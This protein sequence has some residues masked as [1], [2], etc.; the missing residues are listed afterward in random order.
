MLCCFALTS[1][2]QQNALNGISMQKTDFAAMVANDRDMVVLTYL[3]EDPD[4]ITLIG[5]GM[6]FSWGAMFPASMLAQYAGTQ[7][8]GV[9]Y[10]AGALSF[11]GSRMK[12]RVS[13]EV[14]ELERGELETN[15]HREVQEILQRHDIPM[16]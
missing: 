7:L 12:C 11:S 10:F 9:P 5:V 16:K 1:V 15:L 13:A 6:G 4:Q 14:K 2:A 8:I 3:E